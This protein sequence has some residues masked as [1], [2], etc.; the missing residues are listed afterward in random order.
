VQETFRTLSDKR[1]IE[2]AR[3]PDP[4]ANSASTEWDEYYVSNLFLS[5]L[6]NLKFADET[7]ALAVRLGSTQR[8]QSLEMQHLLSIFPRPIIDALGLPVDKD[9]V[10]TSSGGDLLLFANTNDYDVLRGF[11]TGSLFASGYALFDWFYPLLLGVIV[12]FT[13]ALMDA[14]TTRR[15]VEP[16]EFNGQRWMPVFNPLQVV[17]YYAASFYLTSA[18]SGV[19]AFSTLPFLFIRGWIETLLVYLFGFWV[20]RCVAAL[21]GGKN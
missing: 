9:L 20:S 1:S 8:I 19:E 2:A 10:S 11:R 6:C 14:N 18:A 15:R 5:R 7:L 3:K 16:N 4:V 12:A 17:M 13:F 21:L